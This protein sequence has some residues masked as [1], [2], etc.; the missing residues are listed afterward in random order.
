MN[1][2]SPLPVLAS[3][4]ERWPHHD[5]G[6]DLVLGDPT[7]AERWRGNLLSS[8]AAAPDEDFGGG[9]ADSRAEDFLRLW[10]EDDGETD[11]T[12]EGGWWLP[13]FSPRALQGAVIANGGVLATLALLMA[14]PDEGAK[15]DLMGS[16]IV[17][18][19]G[20]MFAAIS[21]VASLNVRGPRMRLARTAATPRLAAISGAVS[22]GALALAVFPLLAR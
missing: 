6:G 13:F 2:T 14:G 19:L 12:R 9:D 8:D 16:A 7:G 20:L 17:V 4:L 22:Y 21:V 15:S 1:D 3:D 5:Q 10:P 18:G 11:R